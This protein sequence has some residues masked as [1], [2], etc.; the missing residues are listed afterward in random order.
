MT[1]PTSDL[2]LLRAYEPIVRYNHGELFYPAAVEGYL[3]ECDLLMGTSERD[4]VVVVP[5]GE[6][7]TEVLGN[8]VAEPGKSLYLRLVQKPL[9]GI[10]LAGWRL[11]VGP[12][13]LQGGRPAGP[14]RALRPPGRRRL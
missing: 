13:A 10:E 9:N 1:D 7:T 2:E 6:L 5:K 11:A 12:A 14:S 3:A 8:Y 4:R